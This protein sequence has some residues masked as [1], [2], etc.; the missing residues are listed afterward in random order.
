MSKEVVSRSAWAATFG[1]NR[2]R[3]SGTSASRAARTSAASRF[4]SAPASF[5]NVEGSMSPWTPSAVRTASL[6]RALES[7]PLNFWSFSG[8]TAS[9]VPY[10]WTSQSDRTSGPTSSPAGQRAAGARSKAKASRRISL[11]LGIGVQ[12]PVYGF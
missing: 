9:A 11:E 1:F 6:P 2:L 12:L 3:D 8:A 5:S 7:V 4:P 10:L